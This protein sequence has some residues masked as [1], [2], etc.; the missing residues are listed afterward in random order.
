MSKTEFS[1][2]LS[3]AAWGF[4]VCGF[5]NNIFDDLTPM[6]CV[7]REKNK[8]FKAYKLISNGN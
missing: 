8:T 5:P 6:L 2:E 3:F 7:Y 4:F 1:N